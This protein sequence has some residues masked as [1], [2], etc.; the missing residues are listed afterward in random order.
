MTAPTD[1]GTFTAVLARSD[2]VEARHQRP[3]PIGKF[4][5]HMRVRFF[6]SCFDRPVSL[7][8]HMEC[9]SAV[10]DSLPAP[11]LVTLLGAPEKRRN[12]PT[13]T[14]GPGSADGH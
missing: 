9:R 1:G 11:E 12:T 3:E 8:L 7:R 2:R 4:E 10:R 5:P 6:A 14:I 13:G